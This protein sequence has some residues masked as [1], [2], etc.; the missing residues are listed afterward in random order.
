[1]LLHPI[2]QTLYPLKKT[3]FSLLLHPIVQAL[4]PLKKTIF[5]LLLH[6][7][8]PTLYPLQKTNFS[9]LLHPIVQA[10]YPLKKTNFSLLL[11]PIVQN[12]QNT[13]PLHKYCDHYQVSSPKPHFTNTVQYYHGLLRPHC[14]NIVTTTM[15]LSGPNVQTL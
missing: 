4:Y 7:I 11:H 6:P 3:N 15:S 12:L 1:M 2:V 5:S 10:L 8:V 9:L 14:I 13:T